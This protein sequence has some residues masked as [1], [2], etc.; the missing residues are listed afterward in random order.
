ML[1]CFVLP[2]SRSHDGRWF[3]SR[4]CEFR[5]TIRV[6]QRH[7]VGQPRS[8]DLGGAFMDPEHGQM[9]GVPSTQPGTSRLVEGPGQRCPES[10]DPQRLCARKWVLHPGADHSGADDTYADHSGADDT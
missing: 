7:Q 8:R 2:L 10:T 1:L 3:V 9:A 4:Y 5:P 6:L